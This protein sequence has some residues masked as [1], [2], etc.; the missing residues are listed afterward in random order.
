MPE[1]D[2]VWKLAR[3]LDRQLTGHTIAR[4]DFRTPRLATRDIAGREVLGHDTHGKHLLTR[5]SATAGSPAATLHSHLKMDGS[6]STLAPGKRLPA[7]LQAHVRLVLTLDDDRA[8]HGIRLHDLDLVPTDREADLV[9]HLG[10]DP[11]RD[12][13]DAAEAV[14]R[15]SADPAL[16]FVSALLDQRAVAGFGNLWANELAFLTGVS[17]WTPI[18]EVDLERL[19]ERGATMLRHSATVQGAYQ[20]TTGSPVRGDDHWVTGRQRQGCRRCRGP[21]SVTAEVPGDAANRRTWWCPACQP[22]PGPEARVGSG[23]GVRVRPGAAGGRPRRSTR[24][25]RGRR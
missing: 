19:V 20:V 24:S 1:G 21:I 2:S 8:V 22:G 23:L 9:G 13:W 6:W 15:L 7:K 5:F 4:S 3:R 25:S 12:D 10:P 16:P 14:R 18:G 17:P 11:L